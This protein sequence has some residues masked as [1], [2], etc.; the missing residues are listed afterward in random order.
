MDI[1]EKKNIFPIAHIRRLLKSEKDIQISA[2]GVEMC[3]T[4]LND[5]SLT[6]Q[7]TILE[8][9]TES[10][11]KKIKIPQLKKALVKLDLNYEQTTDFPLLTKAAT[12]RF[13]KNKESDFW[14]GDEA[15]FVLQN[16]LENYIRILGNLNEIYII[17]YK[18][19]TFNSESMKIAIESLSKG[20]KLNYNEFIRRIFSYEEIKKICEANKISK[21]KTK[22]DLINDL[23]KISI[24]I[25]NI[26]QVLSE[27]IN[28]DELRHRMIR[29]KFPIPYTFQD[30]FNW[31]EIP[32]ITSFKQEEIELEE[33]FDRQ[34]IQGEE[35]EASIEIIQKKKIKKKKKQKIIE[36]N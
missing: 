5:V 14:V 34:S 11:R 23:C 20:I 33:F 17:E 25:E 6:L 4:H 19:K 29:N 22:E 1:D 24:T 16:S 9:M 2:D 7:T 8:I 3:L 35:F 21:R 18:K 36:I 26:L 10:K 13:I 12:K 27:E 15:I 28:F 30:V 32:K 31:V